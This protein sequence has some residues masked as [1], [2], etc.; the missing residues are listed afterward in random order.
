M[1]CCTRHLISKI[2]RIPIVGHHNYYRN[3][4]K[5]KNAIEGQKDNGLICPAWEEAIIKEQRMPDIPLDLMQ[6]QTIQQIHKNYN[7]Q[8]SNLNTK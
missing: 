8:Q 2:I 1:Q 4:R 3:G 6:K 7:Q 5:N